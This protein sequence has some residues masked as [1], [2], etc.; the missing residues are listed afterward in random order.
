MSYLIL[1]ENSGS[2]KDWAYGNFGIKYS[3]VL[4]LRP[5]QYSTDGSYGFMLPESRMSLVAPET[6]AGIKAV[7]ASLV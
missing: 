2:S 1:D 5:S 7:L 6:Y 3:Y 4:E